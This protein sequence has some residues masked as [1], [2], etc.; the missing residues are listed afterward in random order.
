MMKRFL[1]SA[2]L[3]L[4]VS[5]GCTNEEDLGS[6]NGGPGGNASPAE[7]VAACA[8]F[9]TAFTVDRKAKCL[10]VDEVGDGFDEFCARLLSAPGTKTDVNQVTTCAEKLSAIPCDQSDQDIPECVAAFQEAKGTL[11]DGSPCVLGAQCASGSCSGGGLDPDD[12]SCGTCRPPAQVG[13]PCDPDRCT[14]DATCVSTNG[15]AGTC[16]ALVN[17]GESCAEKYYCRRE[18]SC[19]QT[20]K[21]CTR[22]PG[23]GGACGTG[24]LSTN[25]AA[26]L[27]CIDNVCSMPRVA[28]E[29]CSETDN[30]V[31]GL[32]CDSATKVC[33][34]K[35]VISVGDPCTSP[36][37]EKCEEGAYCERGKCTRFLAPGASCVKGGIACTVYHYCGP[38]STCVPI[39]PA[40]CK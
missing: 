16:E 34:E 3:V 23:E 36:E 18:S 39:D 1:S 11:P 37:T 32:F 38:S 8:K 19:D 7:L 24:G 21:T 20:T 35:T 6:R 13:E 10:D 14:S 30:C 15:S 26:S 9:R 12:F 29:A 4:V 25:C 33:T 17:D 5:A 27:N 2:V 22:D 31:R 28:G 40:V